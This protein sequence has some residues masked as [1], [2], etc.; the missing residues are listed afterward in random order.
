MQYTFFK[1]HNDALV[2]NEMELRS[3]QKYSVMA[4]NAEKEI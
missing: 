3:L 1:I 2:F 4:W